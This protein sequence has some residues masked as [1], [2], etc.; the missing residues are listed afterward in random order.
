MALCTRSGTIPVVS[1]QFPLPRYGQCSRHSEI[2]KI[3]VV[4]PMQMFAVDQNKL[5]E[6]PM[7]IIQS[8]PLGLEE[9]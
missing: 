4:S 2:R 1:T 9:Q 5:D 8:E 6:M 7:T 3:G